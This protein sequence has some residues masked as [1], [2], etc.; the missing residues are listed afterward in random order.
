MKYIIVTGS[1]GL[2]GSQAVTYFAKKG[3]KIIGIDND[4][5]KYFF[6]QEG[7]NKQNKLNLIKSA[8]NYEHFNYD[9]RDYKMLESVFKQRK[10]KIASIIHTAA[11]PSHDW[12][13]KEPI[14]D[15]TI[16]ANGT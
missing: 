8:I 3:Y 5:R 12:A 15:F 9:I 14:T 1:A 6:G 2:I 16:N 10:T 4:S 11:Q 7:S 13:K